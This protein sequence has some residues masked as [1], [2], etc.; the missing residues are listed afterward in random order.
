MSKKPTI[1]QKEDGYRL[2]WTNSG[3]MEAFVDVFF[4]D[5]EKPIEELSYPKFGKPLEVIADIF[6]AEALAR[7]KRTVELR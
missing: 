5:E 7:A 1:T 2:V 3:R 4:G 6:K